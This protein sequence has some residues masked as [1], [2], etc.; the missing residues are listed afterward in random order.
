MSSDYS[1]ISDISPDFIEESKKLCQTVPNSKKK[2]GRY[3]KHEIETRRAEVY[4]LHFDLGMSARKIANLMKINRNTINEDIRYWYSK[5]IDTWNVLSPE[6]QIVKGLLRLEI[7]RNRLRAE[8]GNA[9]NLT[10]RLTVERLLS[11]VESRIVGINTRL[12]DT[13]IRMLATVTDRLNKWMEKN[14]NQ[15]RYISAFETIAVSKKAREQIAKVIEEDKVNPN[16]RS[17]FCD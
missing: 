5:A 3:T 9:S 17:S 15:T 16:H 13:E 8:L 2:G 11:D 12:C 1:G 10:E 6:D 14:G 7:Q 4:R